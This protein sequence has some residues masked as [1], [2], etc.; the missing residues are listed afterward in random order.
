MTQKLQ[1]YEFHCISFAQ[2]RAEPNAG[3][4]KMVAM[5][6]K[7]SRLPSPA[8]ATLAGLWGTCEEIG[9]S[10]S[11]AEQIIVI[12]EWISVLYGTPSNVFRGEILQ[13][14]NATESKNRQILENCKRKSP[15]DPF[16]TPVLDCP[17]QAVSE[18]FPSYKNEASLWTRAFSKA[19]VLFERNTGPL[20]L[21]DFERKLIYAWISN[22]IKSGEAPNPRKIFNEVFRRQPKNPNDID[23]A[24]NVLELIDAVGNNFG[25]P[26]LKNEKK[27]QIRE[28]GAAAY[29]S[30]KENPSLRSI[31]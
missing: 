2:D 7:I 28:L 24:K 11:Q 26:P 18:L 29:L 22:A 30:C 4:I 27:D 17:F 20:I 21:R 12:L 5:R 3:Y 6:L 15:H 19:E 1:P 25:L 9:I 8:E 13:E 23:A 16:I 10:L 14:F 31:G